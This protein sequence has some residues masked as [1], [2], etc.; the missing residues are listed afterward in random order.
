MNQKYVVMQL[1][2][3]NKGVIT[4]SEVRDAG[5]SYKTI[6]R[7]HQSGAL[8]KLGHGLYMDPNYIEDEYFI[9]QYRCKE[10]IFSHETA[11]YFHDLSDRAPLTMML[12]IPSGYNTRLLVEDKYKF[13]YMNPALHN[14]GRIEI[15]SPYGHTIAIY[16]KE[17]TICDV[18][19]K[20]QYLDTDLVTDAIKR[21]MQTPGANFAKLIEYAETFKVKELIRSYLEVL[22]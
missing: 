11:L 3:K 17:R 15:E 21:Y 2:E 6:Q 9:T 7:L 16:D 8:E 4:S 13:F 22:Q 14:I 18:I 1:L 20:K 19:K 10:G 12:T 5:V